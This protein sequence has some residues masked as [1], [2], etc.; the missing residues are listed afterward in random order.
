MKRV[1]VHD[2]TT[3]KSLEKRNHM[4]IANIGNLIEY[5]R[6]DRFP[7][8]VYTAPEYL[9]GNRCFLSLK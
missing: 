8:N 5:A 9:D 4:H 1:M 2:T 7:G 3:S 6:P